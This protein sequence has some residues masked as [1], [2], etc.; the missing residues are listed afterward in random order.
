MLK[1]LGD[2]VLVRPSEGEERTP[3]GILLPDTARK[4]PQEGKVLAIGSGRVTKKGTRTPIGVK[5]GDTVIYSKWSGT[6]VKV[7]EEDLILVEEDSILAV[8]E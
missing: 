5:V 2:R 1:P 7:G 4:K 8:R 3:G 6:E